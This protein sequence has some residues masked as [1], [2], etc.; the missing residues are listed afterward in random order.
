VRQRS[1]NISWLWPWASNEI[2]RKVF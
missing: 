2:T 1:S